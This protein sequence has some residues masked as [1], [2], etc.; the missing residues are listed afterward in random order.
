MNKNKKYILIALLASLLF[1]VTI[2]FSVWIILSEQASSEHGYIAPKVDP[3]TATATARTDPMYAGED[4]KI[5]AS[6][7]PYTYTINE[8]EKTWKI[9][10]EISVDWST[11]AYTSDATPGVNAAGKAAVNITLTPTG[12]AA[13]LF[14]AKTIPVTVYVTPVAQYG[15]TFYPTIDQALA[16]VQSATSGTIYVIPSGNYKTETERANVAKT[17]TPVYERNADG[18]YKL[19]EDGNKIEV[20][21]V[22][23]SGVTLALP[24]AIKSDTSTGN[25][26]IEYFDNN[27]YAFREIARNSSVKDPQYDTVGTLATNNAYTTQSTYCHNIVYV[28][29]N[30]TLQGDL[31]IGGVI[32][33]G[34][35]RTISGQTC[36]RHAQLRL[37]DN[38]SFTAA[39]GSSTTCYGFI[40]GLDAPT[41]TITDPYERV[42]FDSGSSLLM[43]FVFYDWQSGQVIMMMLN[44]NKTYSTTQIGDIKTDIKTA[45]F[46][47][48]PILRYVFPNI[49]GK[50]T[51]KSGASASAF[52]TANFASQD[53]QVTETVAVVSSV[54]GTFI[55]LPSNASLKIHYDPNISTDGAFGEM[56]LH[57]YGGATL[58]AL[59]L[60]VDLSKLHSMA[61]TLG[62]S[63]VSMT[64]KG[65]FLPLAYFY[66]VYFHGT[67]DGGTASYDLTG[68]K[69]A[70]L[71]GSRVTIDRE[72]TVNASS[73]LLYEA[74]PKI[75]PAAYAASS[76]PTKTAASITLNGILTINSTG[77]LPGALAG[78]NITSSQAGGKLVINGACSTYDYNMYSYSSTSNDTAIGTVYT[79]GADKVKTYFYADIDV[80]VT[81]AKL[82]GYA[83][84]Q[85]YEDTLS[86]SAYNGGTYTTAG[87]YYS[88]QT[89][90]AD[91]PDDAADDK[92]AWYSGDMTVTFMANGVAAKTVKPDSIYNGLVTPPTVTRDYYTFSHWC[93]SD[94]CTAGDTCANKI[95]FAT[96]KFFTTTTLYAAWKA[97]TYT[98]N[99]EYVYTGD[100]SELTKPTL[101]G[102]IEFTVLS[103]EE[104]IGLDQIN[105][106]V[107]DGEDYKFNGWYTD[108][109]CSAESKVTAIDGAT[110]LAL[111]NGQKIYGSWVLSTITI[112]YNNGGDAFN[113]YFTNTSQYVTFDDLATT[114]LLPV[115]DYSSN[116]TREYFFDGWYY[117]DT[118][119]T[120]L[121]FVDTKDADNTTYDLT[122]RWTQKVSITYTANMN[123]YADLFADRGYATYWH[124]SGTVVTLPNVTSRDATATDANLK[125]YFGSWTQDGNAL[126]AEATS[127]T[128]NANTVVNITWGTKATLTVDY[129]NGTNSVLNYTN[130]VVYIIPGR[131]HTIGKNVN[132]GDSVIT[133]KWFFKQWTLSN[134]TIS[135]S[136]ITVNSG[137]TTAKATVVWGSKHIV[138][139]IFTSYYGSAPY[140][141][142]NYNSSTDSGD[143]IEVASGGGTYY[144]VPGTSIKA[145]VD[146]EWKVYKSNDTGLYI[147]DGDKPILYTS[148]G[149][150]DQ[151]EVY[152]DITAGEGVT[153]KLE[154]KRY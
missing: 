11:V 136:T 154:F 80:L 135:G 12:W 50:Y 152:T 149:K 139:I 117:G 32:H 111:N 13:L 40:V 86:L 143:K 89:A 103:T 146:G 68:Q 77:V 14:S 33:S 29:A 47:T 108:P 22:I 75:S 35:N 144:V 56:D 23:P 70:L 142:L 36:G 97:N 105:P 138:K 73:L 4:L 44:V 42:L 151:A 18:T 59:S 71:P 120:D 129:A 72:A 5:S 79:S 92:Y 128:L 8:T 38:G 6:T 81:S 148:Y 76:Y 123:V 83:Y 134:C 126:S 51:I 62:L 61:G 7:L 24:Y 65:K 15:S 69:V 125:Y 90:G 58:N 54:E 121:S 3:G 127:I 119:V 102:S 118:K 39:S 60:N 114:G 94:G 74:A 30:L 52:A 48:S 100:F 16:A 78:G 82:G 133:N 112:N 130:E 85:K 113:S 110:L 115:T 17:I 28:A 9:P 43:P 88:T 106:T 46:I 122:A 2:G 116:T 1:T 101:P 132:A 45:D 37:V 31:K 27:T 99:F 107:P 147:D 57:F 10:H 34:I 98:V 140:A 55:T 137:V 41:S 87:T 63:T 19:D 109:S 93:T 145:Y 49:V 91:T 141:I 104:D 84:Y 21:R 64:S 153:T 131:T 66:D 124:K 53:A 25:P 96:Q 67:K 20:P 26:I 95:N 150:Y